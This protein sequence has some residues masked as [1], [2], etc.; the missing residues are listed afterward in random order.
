[1]ETGLMRLYK[2][3]SYNDNLNMCRDYDTFETVPRG[4]V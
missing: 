4:A 2:L 1:M 3:G